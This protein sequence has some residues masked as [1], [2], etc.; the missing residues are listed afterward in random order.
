MEQIRE[1][2]LMLCRALEANY[3]Q[4]GYCSLQGFV[5]EEL[6]KFYKIIQVGQHQRSVHAFVDKKTGDVYKP[7][8]WKAPAKHVRFNIIKQF[9]EVL[10]KADWAGGYLY[11]R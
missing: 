10:E 2:C 4:H 9:D 6:R 1:N 5:V 3:H 7:A 11:I 8:G